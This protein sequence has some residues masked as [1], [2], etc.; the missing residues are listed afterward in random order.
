MT[1][2]D[3]VVRRPRLDRRAAERRRRNLLL[4]MCSGV[5]VALGVVVLL[6]D[7][8]PADEVAARDGGPARSVPA[9]AADLAATAAADP[10]TAPPTTAPAPSTTAPPTTAPPDDALPPSGEGR[11]VVFSIERQRMWWVDQDGTVLRTAL[12]S[13]RE[14]TPTTGTFQVFSKSLNAT[15]LDGSRMDYFVRFT[16]GPNGWAIGFHDIPRV[17]GQPVQTEEQLGQALSAGCIRQATDDAIYTWEFLDVG[18]TVVVV[19]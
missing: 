18:D 12:V 9:T 4:G 3:H 10:L 19:A 8:D 13:G 11:R 15:G 5:V 6:L 1:D 16:H 14:A 17:D 7:G 2:P